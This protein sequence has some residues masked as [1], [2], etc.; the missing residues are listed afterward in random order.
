MSPVS[1]TEVLMNSYASITFGINF[2]AKK[3]I[4]STL[5]AYTTPKQLFVYSKRFINEMFLRQLS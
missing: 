4:D 5:S 1:I 3:E 2:Y